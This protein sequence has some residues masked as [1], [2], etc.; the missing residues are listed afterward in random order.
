MEVILQKALAGGAL[1]R[2]EVRTL[3]LAQGTDE[4]RLFE[5]AEEIRRRRFGDRIFLYGFVY[6]STHCRNDCSFCYYRRSNRIGRYRKS[7]DEILSIADSLAAAGVHL[8]DLTMGEDPLYHAERFETVLYLLEEI[9]K[10]TGL[11]VMISPGVVEHDMID[12][13]ASL[14]VEWYALYQETYSRRLYGKLRLD[15]S[16]DERMAAKLHARDKGMHIEEGLLVGIGET[17]EELADSILAMSNIGAEQLRVMRFVPQE[18]I[19]LAEEPAADRRA[20]QKTIA[21]LRLLNPDA[22][23]PASLDVDGLAGL[24]ER[25]QAGANVVTSIILPHTGLAGVA[26]SKMDIDDGS[27]T[28][29]GVDRVL[30]GMGLRAASAADYRAFLQLKDRGKGAPWTNR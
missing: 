10:R 13:F 17:P 1:D 24:K 23:I 25:L 12:R 4:R 26:Q 20:E 27:R 29:E 8:L 16:Y 15:Q 3:L 7:T 18:G 30:S 14:G 22:L 9:R 6:F 11:P 5:A 28:V 2:N 21:I 19:P